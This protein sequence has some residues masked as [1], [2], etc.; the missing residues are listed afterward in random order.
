MAKY[1]SDDLKIE[2]DNDGDSLI[3]MSQHVEEINDVI[4]HDTGDDT[5]QQAGRENRCGVFF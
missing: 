1:G 5:W 3:D 2:V 4:N